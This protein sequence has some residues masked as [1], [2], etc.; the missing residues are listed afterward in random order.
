[1]AKASAK[2][3]AAAPV[4]K[5]GNANKRKRE[6]K[7]LEKTNKKEKVQE[8]ES[9]EEEEED[10]EEAETKVEDD[11][12]QEEDDDT[13]EDDD[14][15]ME[16]DKAEKTKEL[17]DLPSIDFSANEVSTSSGNYF[18]TDIPFS[19]TLAPPSKKPLPEPST[20]SNILPVY[21]Y[22]P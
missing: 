7:L 21:T 10:D 1:M 4:A 5:D 12:E 19:S 22:F 9:E 11:D 16:E 20:F 8:P 3:A 2:P 17:V 15:E 14:E 13:V 6:E 18:F